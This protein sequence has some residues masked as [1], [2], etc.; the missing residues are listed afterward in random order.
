[1]NYYLVM[2]MTKI[3]HEPAYI[4][5]GGDG[6]TPQFVQAPPALSWTPIGVFKARKAED[7]C[8]A[9]AKKMQQFGSFL[10]IEG[11]PWGI[12]L[13]DI[14]ASEFGLNDER[15]LSPLE[16]AENRSRELE[17]EAGID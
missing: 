10:A 16:R 1:M 17:R 11:Y 9:A 8:K 14:E 5:R 7:A 6:R 3:Q 2:G 13:M 15:E 12:D 4:G